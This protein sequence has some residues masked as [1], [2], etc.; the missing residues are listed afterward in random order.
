[1]ILGGTLAQQHAASLLN[2]T[3]DLFP[4]QEVTQEDLAEVRTLILAALLGGQNPTDI[5][6]REFTG[7][8][9]EDA[10]EA[11]TN[12][13]DD[14]P[15]AS[16]QRVFRR[17]SSFREIEILTGSPGWAW[18][19]TPTRTLGP[20]QDRA[21][22]SHWFDIFDPE[23]HFV[24]NVLGDPE[25]IALLPAGT[26]PGAG[27]LTLPKGSLWMRAKILDPAAPANEWAGI[28]IDGGTATPSGPAQLGGAGI[29][30]RPQAGM[31]VSV[32]LATGGLAGFPDS[33]TIGMSPLGIV[34]GEF[35]PGSVS[36][37][38][39]TITFEADSGQP[40][41]DP[42]LR[43]MLFPLK[44]DPQTFEGRD[45]AS[46]K[47]AIPVCT[48]TPTTLAAV[49]GPGSVAL[50]VDAG[51]EISLPGV[52][53]GAFTL[54]AARI[55]IGPGR[56]AIV[57][58][59]SNPRAIH[60]LSAWFE[61]R[62][63]RRSAV[64]MRWPS[65]EPLWMFQFDGGG[66]V[67][68]TKGELTLHIDRPLRASGERLE[69]HIST[70]QVIEQDR[71]IFHGSQSVDPTRRSALALSN[72]LLTVAE[73]SLLHLCA[74]LS[75]PT[76]MNSGALQFRLPLFQLL[77]TLRDPYVTNFD[78]R[79][80]DSPNSDTRA[81]VSI[82]WTEP[83]DAKLDIRLDPPPFNM[84]ATSPLLPQSAQFRPF[85]ELSSK[86]AETVPQRPDEGLTL[87]DV[88]T[89][90]GQFGIALGFG[91]QPH[92]GVTIRDLELQISGV[93]AT[94]FLLPQFQCEPV[95]NRHNPKV[96]AEPEG[97]VH[98][99]DDGGPSQVSANTVR[100]I[101]VRPLVLL[102]EVVRAY[103]EEQRNA[104]LLFNL[105]FGIQAVATLNP[106]DR[107]FN[108]LPQL[109]V[110]RP[111]FEGTDGIPQLRLL[112]G[113][114][115]QGRTWIKGRS[116]Q[117]PNVAGGPPP[118][119][120]GAVVGS[121]FNVA[122]QTG[123]P[124]ERIDLAGFGAS[125]FSHWFDRTNPDVGITQVSLEAFNG[126][127]SY[128]RVM[129]T[130]WLI[131]CFSRMVRT[132][133]FERY[134]SA[135]IIRWDS[136]WVA[137]T[138][139]NYQHTGHTFH[140]CAVG[141]AFD[142]RE[143]RDTDYI[144][145]L[146]DGSQLQAVYY[147]ADISIE[148]PTRGGD[149]NGRIP[150]RR[151]L[152][153]VQ[154]L[155]LPA[156]PP[157]P[158]NPITAAVIDKFRLTE[159]FT[160][161]GPL[162]G[163]V[164]C[165]IR[166]GASKHKMK[167]TRILADNAANN[168][169]S[170]GPYGL[171]QLNAAGEWSVSR[172]NNGTGAVSPIDPG[173]DIPLIRLGAGAFRFADPSTLFDNN[174][175]T[176]YA[177]L[178]SS[179]PQR[180]LFPRPKIEPASPL[181]TTAIPPLLADPYSLLKAPGLFPPVTQAIPF[182]V[183][184]V[185][186]DSIDDVLH[187][188]PNPVNINVGAPA[189]NLVKT[190]SWDADLKYIDNAGTATKFVIDS[191]AKWGMKSTGITQS[192]TFPLFGEVMRIVHQIDAPTI[193]DDSFPDPQVLFDKALKDVTD[194]L[195]MLQEWAPNLPAPLKVDASFKAP[196]FWLSAVVDF[197]IEDK[198]GNAI[199]CGMGKLRGNLKVGAELSV[200]IMKGTINGAVFFEVTGSWQQQ[201]FP[202]I[203]GGGLMRFKVRA[204]QDGDTTLEL[205]ACVTGSIGGDLIP[206]LVSVEAT[207]KYGYFLFTNPITPGFLASIEGRAKLLSGLLG[208]KMGIE[209]RIGVTRTT[210]NLADLKHICH[211][212]GEILV[213]GTVTLA[214]LVEERKSFR[215]HFDVDVD[216]KMLLLA[217]K[218]GVLPV[219]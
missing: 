144:V 153:F 30:L 36:A 157:P 124:I 11:I 105:P 45:V 202:L 167:V 138:P 2:L 210:H 155:T 214:W 141:G 126:R 119:A 192:L 217:A 35:G 97:W 129:I 177:F 103:S 172:V 10:E 31:K 71:V 64:E 23:A 72:A 115:N 176:D 117:T 18:A 53:G 15:A 195:R 78:P 94:V 46:V 209:G 95:F 85:D 1:M 151:H 185:G 57:A 9:A 3:G 131:P 205:D 118:N 7:D 218:A 56:V 196:R 127:T 149:K 75:S 19:Q 125:I 92:A 116:V 193:K 4:A 142:I 219:P 22:C 204:D 58:A 28:R 49:D 67:F 106:L 108:T 197:K 152:G 40:S 178:F 43:H 158:N 148:N 34:V 154:L 182:N 201:I 25:P 41:Y 146:S 198:E 79:R 123:V 190:G 191:A 24:V 54:G 81:A 76:E 211:L 180:L 194:V 83:F 87:V 188:S 213:A 60:I 51:L 156:V 147:D 120:L 16:K 212:H 61:D 132:I 207:V 166:I 168:E 216:W 20:F 8:A 175:G 99:R 26:V 12:L 14:P 162:G 109:E 86:F 89:N 37:L 44:S 6:L 159:L 82:V 110:I 187:L 163:P 130:S 208:F 32:Q 186:L 135:A 200:E 98:F 113:T 169:F 136:G 91:D 133:T 68:L 140:K 107:Q 62:V 70:F 145:T 183:P 171:P 47:W 50:M 55:L 122:F 77:P 102:D 161:E 29:L 203:Y 17:S 100:L 27:Q 128:E 74:A 93:N 65:R 73:P 206:G 164:D 33:V 114:T 143:V 13:G 170:V 174:P 134:G 112:A 90:S 111:R 80:T 165:E 139:G 39:S 189:F 52:E 181:I 121:G 5:G 104:A 38:N 63:D 137:T 84:P 59:A 42:V 160:R 88:S 69:S 48:G 199:D 150:A 96:P 21:G 101:Q 215:T 66:S 184:N 173:R 179:G